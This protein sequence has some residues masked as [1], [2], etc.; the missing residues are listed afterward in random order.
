MGT[1]PNCTMLHDL[2]VA[3]QPSG[4]EIAITTGQPTDVG[5]CREPL[6]PYVVSVELEQALFAGGGTASDS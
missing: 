4:L 3:V 2:D 6:I 5:G 1:D